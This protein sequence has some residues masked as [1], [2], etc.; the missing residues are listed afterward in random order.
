[1]VL[2]EKE[3][4]PGLFVSRRVD[5]PVATGSWRRLHAAGPREAPRRR[6]SLMP[7]MRL[8]PNS[9]STIEGLDSSGVFNVVVISLRSV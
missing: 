2:H 7:T 3:G 6:Q 8:T 1:M 5:Q 9:K 4:R